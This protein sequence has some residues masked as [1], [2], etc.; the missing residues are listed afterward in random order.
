M[1]NK[2]INREFVYFTGEE[3][4]WMDF[5]GEESSFNEKQR[6]DFLKHYQKAARAWY[7]DD[8]LDKKACTEDDIASFIDS[9]R[10][11][12]APTF[13]KEIVFDKMAAQTAYK[14]P[15]FQ[16][17]HLYC[18]A[19][20][21]NESIVFMGRKTRPTP[22]AKIEL[23]NVKNAVNI[24]M[25]I[26]IPAEYKCNQIRKAG[27]A[28]PGRTIEIRSH[29]LDIAKIK[30]FNTGEVFALSA[31]K[32]EPV[33]TKIG[34][35]KFDDWNEL[36]I[37]VSDKVMV[38]VNGEITDNLE[39][40]NK[41]LANNIFFDGGMFPHSEWKVKNI[42][43]DEKPFQYIL[44]DNQEKITTC[45]CE[46]SLPYAIGGA[47]NQDRRIYLTKEFDIL[48]FEHAVL[49]IDTIDPCGKVWINRNLVLDADD[50]TRREVDVTRY[51]KTGRNVLKIMVE[52]RPAEVY[53]YWHR[54]DDCHNGW[55]CGNVKLLLTNETFIKNMNVFTTSI[56]SE[57]KACGRVE[58]NLNNP[59]NGVVKFFAQKFSPEE[60]E[61]VFL[62]QK[63]VHDSRAELDFEESLELWD[64]QNPVLYA[65][66][67]I[68]YDEN[69]NAVDD[70]VTE[71]GFRVIEQKNGKIYLNN[72]KEYL[73]GALLMQFLPPLKDVP[74]NH[75]CPT[76]R[77]IAMQCLMLKNMN[78]NLMRLHLLGY[79]TNDARYAKICD[80][81]GIMLVWTTRFIDSLETLVWDEKWA[82]GEHY[83]KQIT[84]VI[85]HPSII[86]YEGSN[87]FHAFEL[88][89]ID[90]MYD[91]FVDIVDSVDSSRLLSPV[92]DL[93]YYGDYIFYM[94]NGKWD[95]KGNGVCSGKGWMH[96]RVIRSD[97]PYG[98]YCGYGGAWENM[99]NLPTWQRIWDNI[100]CSK[101]PVLA[102][103]Y[104]ITGLPNPNTKEALENDYVESYERR[105]EVGGFGRLFLQEEWKE[106]QG[107]QAFCAY[108]ATKN[109]RLQGFDG[110]TWCCLMS[111]ANN[112]SYM[113]PPIDFYGYKKLCFYALK[114]SYREIFACKKDLFVSYG[115][116]DSITPAIVNYSQEGRYS[117]KVTVSDENGIILDEL[118]YG[119]LNIDPMNNCV[120]P[121]F[122]P[123]WMEKGYYI[124]SFCIERID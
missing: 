7:N 30:F 56:N 124:I 45:P 70:F 44:N 10:T 24:S 46:V 73:R 1:S 32:W 90:K 35:I 9:Y 93:Y 64:T 94:S 25:S 43:I 112:G 115:T 52:P 11:A 78:G 68:L 74:V 41:G 8:A 58:V 109:M 76:D 63:K 75:N 67:C 6:L 3:K 5:T 14:E 55:F 28:H 111:G 104:A 88:A 38:C 83:A 40:T 85:N 36:D 61:K 26:F 87:E 54:H 12:S 84:E 114:D 33:Y 123:S 42:K 59:F 22:C 101:F 21:E 57:N 119:V 96:P 31:D 113:K 82:E 47:E 91:S 86:M 23:E 110:Q 106:S 37:S 99:R 34:S 98:F 95:S 51:L 50:F 48:E 69:D 89:T 81:L 121:E 92:S 105:D 60:G 20:I 66:T 18:G 27:T 15:E 65:V 118:N 122:K 39:R 100:K 13:R 72:K 108:N 16:N 17:V 53:Y 77:Q 62:G 107:L 79:G 80:R 49:M 102:T 2:I 120:L 19:Y 29:T 4:R 71:T 97:H 103:E 117:L 116:E